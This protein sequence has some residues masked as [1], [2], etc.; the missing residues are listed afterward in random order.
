M[1]IIFKVRMITPLK[2]G[3]TPSLAALRTPFY[4]SSYLFIVF[5]LEKPS[6]VLEIGVESGGDGHHVALKSFEGSFNLAQIAVAVHSDMV[7]LEVYRSRIY[8]PSLTVSLEYAHRSI[9]EMQID[10][11]DEDPSSSAPDLLHGD[12]QVVEKA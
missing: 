8:N 6:P 12:S 2:N 5:S 11:D 9:A 10:I 7:K 4:Y 1:Y 3:E